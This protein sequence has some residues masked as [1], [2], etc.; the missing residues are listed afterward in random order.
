MPQLNTHANAARPLRD[1]HWNDTAGRG[2]SYLQKCVNASVDVSNDDVF[3]TLQ[4]PGTLS[5]GMVSESVIS[6]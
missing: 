1:T 5:L 2:S 3:T 6:S 4:P